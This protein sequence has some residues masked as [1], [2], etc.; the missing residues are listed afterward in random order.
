M[1]TIHWFSDHRCFKS[2]KETSG[3]EN[4][5]EELISA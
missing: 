2:K 3:L 5:V 4:D 1:Y